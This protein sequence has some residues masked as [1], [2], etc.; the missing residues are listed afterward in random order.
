MGKR[1]FVAVL[2]A[3]VLLTGLAFAGVATLWW[4]APADWQEWVSITI[5]G[6]R[7]VP[8]DLHWGHG[9]GAAA[10]MALALL[11]VLVVVVPMALLLGLLGTALG[12]VLGLLGAL[13]GLAVVLSPLLVVGLLVWLVLRDRRA[14][15]GRTPDPPP[16]A[17]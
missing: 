6:R 15:P 16:P 8:P 1:I 5:D 2:L 3:F 7:W 17:A 12:T 11:V 4:L 9:L 13:L 14:P 10:G